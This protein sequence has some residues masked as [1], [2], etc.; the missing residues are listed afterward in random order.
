MSALM[1]EATDL[2][3]GPAATQQPARAANDQRLATQVVFTSGV[4]MLNLPA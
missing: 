4:C 2:V 1:P 3:Y